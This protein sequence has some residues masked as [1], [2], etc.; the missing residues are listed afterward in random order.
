MPSEAEAIE[1]LTECGLSEYEARCFVS[2]T[3]LSEGTAKEISQLAD[4]PQS[5]VYDITEELYA[6]G[7]IDIQQSDPKRYTAMSV[8]LALTRLEREY[9]DHLDTANEHLQALEGR[10]AEDTGAWQVAN[11]EDVSLRLQKHIAE[12]TDYIY[13]LVAHDALL[14]EEL[15]EMLADAVDRELAVTVEVPSTDARATVHERIPSAEVAVTDFDGSAATNSHRPGRLLMADGE[16]ILLSARREG[17]VPNDVEETGIWGT[18]VGHGLV[19]WAEEMLYDRRAQLS[20][21]T[22]AE[23]D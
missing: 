12:A 8:D 1:A 11:R 19:V 16:T 13:L 7:L 20:F 23:A 21:D 17:L 15:I 2:L 9:T 22:A 5:R 6:K 4:I 18:A 14:T 10:N 3:Q